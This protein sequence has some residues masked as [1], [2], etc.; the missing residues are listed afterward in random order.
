MDIVDVIVNLIIPVVF[1]IIGSI[2]VP[3]LK[4]KKLFEYVE[5]GVHAAEQMFGS[6]YGEEKLLFVKGWIQKSFKVSDEDLRNII[7][8]VVY[9]MNRLKEVY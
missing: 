8:A 7:E 3:Y 1:V 5:I 6:G 4:E 2:L 9:E